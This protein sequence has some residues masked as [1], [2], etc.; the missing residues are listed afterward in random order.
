MALYS[1]VLNGLPFIKAWGL[2]IT[3]L[4]EWLWECKMNTA[5]TGP[6]FPLERRHGEE[7]V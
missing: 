6:F 3:G 7:R 1:V 5:K 2:G 4:A